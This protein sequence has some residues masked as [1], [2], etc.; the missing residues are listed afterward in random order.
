MVKNI[1]LPNATLQ[2]G[3]SNLSRVYIGWI[4]YSNLVF[5]HVESI[6]LVPRYMF[7]IYASRPRETK[8]LL[9]RI[10]E[11]NLYS[12]SFIF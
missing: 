7:C 6:K 10:A 5:L 1:F 8:V 11:A 12:F 4:D 9:L 3:E 2:R